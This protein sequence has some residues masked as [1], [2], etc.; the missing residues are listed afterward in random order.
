MKKCLLIRR[1]TFAKELVKMLCIYLM[2]NEVLL[3]VLLIF[4]TASN[5]SLEEVLLLPW[6]RVARFTWGCE[7]ILE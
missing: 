5:D 1:V 2:G 7:G 3:N 6:F 4:H